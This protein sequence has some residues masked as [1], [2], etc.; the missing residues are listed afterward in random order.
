MGLTFSCAKHWRSIA[1]DA[2][3]KAGIQSGKCILICMVSCTVHSDGE[4]S[5]G[6]IS[7]SVMLMQLQ[8][9]ESKREVFSGDCF[10]EVGIGAI[11]EHDIRTFCDESVK[12]N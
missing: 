12:R 7:A 3:L 8:N 10:G 4:M 6:L 9:Q 1:E 2:L 11:K 5:D